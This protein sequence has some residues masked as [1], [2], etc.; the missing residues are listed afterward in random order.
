MVSAIWADTIAT[1][2][3]DVD[4]RYGVGPWPG[5]RAELLH[6]ETASGVWTAS[7]EDRYGTVGCRADLA[8]R[9]RVHVLGME[10][11]WAGTPG[12]AAVIAVDTSLAAMEMA[13]SGEFSTTVLSRFARAAIMDG[14]FVTAEWATAD[15]DEAH[16]VVTPADRTEV[17]AEA[18]QFVDWL[19]WNAT[20][21]TPPPG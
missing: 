11:P 6:R 17:S 9:P 15:I 10:D 19:R 2:D 20:A 18:R 5:H 21:A 3:I 12:S 16:W 1:D 14:R 4:V 13:A 8:V 7:F